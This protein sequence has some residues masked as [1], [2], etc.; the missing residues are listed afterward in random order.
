MWYGVGG[1][2]GAVVLVVIIL[3]ATGVFGGG[4]SI[5]GEL[6]DG[7]IQ[8]LIE[9]GHVE[10]F[11]DAPVTL[12]EFGDFQCPFCRDFHVNTLD[13]V[14]QAYVDTGVVKVVYNH[15]AFLG[16]ESLR[17]A[18]ASE[19]A[20]DQD[21]FFAY[22]DVLFEQQGPENEG[23]LTTARLIEFAE[24]AEL[25]TAAFE[26]CLLN[27]PHQQTILDD[28]AFGSDLG[29]NSTPTVLINGRRVPNPLDV[30]AVINAIEAARS[31]G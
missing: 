8:D 7:Q 30:N 15:F 29:V 31:E 22:H 18:E 19:C 10:G 27:R 28:R 2:G 16:E 4:G 24:D 20:A 25:D 21:R 23:Y 3:F 1:I 12:I 11:E 6:S 17:A 5:D 13:L 26:T 9:R 14:R